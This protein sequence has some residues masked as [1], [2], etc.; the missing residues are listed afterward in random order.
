MFWIKKA[1]AAIVLGAGLT[2]GVAGLGLVP[3]D[4]GQ[5]IAQAP[6]AKRSPFKAPEPPPAKSPPKKPTRMEEIRAAEMKLEAD[7]KFLEEL[8]KRYEEEENARVAELRMRS[9]EQDNARQPRIEIGFAD[10][11][12]WASDFSYTENVGGMKVLAVSVF[13]PNHLTLM[14]KRAQA[15]PNAPKAIHLDVIIGSAQQGEK[16]KVSAIKLVNAVVAAGITKVTYTGMM[17]AEIDY[18]TKGKEKNFPRDDGTI[19]LAMST[20]PWRIVSDK[21]TKVDGKEIDLNAAFPKRYRELMVQPAAEKRPTSA[22]TPQQLDRVVTS[23]SENHFVWLSVGSKA[24]YKVGDVV[25]IWRILGEKNDRG[26]LVG[27]IK[28]TVVEADKAFGEDTD[29]PK[30]GFAPRF[31]TTDCVFVAYRNAPVKP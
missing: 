23:V 7:K 27:S 11:G 31:L 26:A 19:G 10:A 30:P 9:E 1:V 21:W 22:I 6:E 12:G 29:K 4:G 20:E 3:G 18:E 17:L 2:A 13:D 24:G 25:E 5:A 16:D 28:L 14:L 8:R 15:D